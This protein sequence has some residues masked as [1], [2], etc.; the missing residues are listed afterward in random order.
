[1][2]QKQSNDQECQSQKLY[3][4]YGSDLEM[5]ATDREDE[6]AGDYEDHLL[7]NH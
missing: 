6:I 4:L 2:G 1:M 7:H 3:R 5:E